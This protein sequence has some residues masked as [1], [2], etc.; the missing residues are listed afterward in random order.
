MKIDYNAPIYEEITFRDIKLYSKTKNAIYLKGISI[1]T[2]KNYLYNFDENNQAI[3]KALKLIDFNLY[4]KKR[5][6]SY[7]LRFHRQYDSQMR[8]LKLGI[9]TKAFPN[10]LL[11]GIKACVKA[12]SDLPFYEEF[13]RDYFICYNVDSIIE[14]AYTLPE[15]EKEMCKKLLISS[16]QYYRDLDDSYNEL[17][18]KSEET[19]ERKNKKKTKDLKENRLKSKNDNAIEPN[20][21]VNDLGE[22]TE[23]DLKESK[24]S[25]ET[26]DSAKVYAVKAT[27][28]IRQEESPVENDLYNYNSVA[29]E[30]HLSIKPPKSG[31]KEIKETPDTLRSNKSTDYI[32]KQQFNSGIGEKG[33]KLVLQNEIAKLKKWGLS[34]GLIQKVRRV[35]LE[36]DDYGYDILS[37]DKEG[38]EH[39]IEV[40]TTTKDVKKFSFII[41]QNELEKAKKYAEHYSVAIVFDILD[42]P[43]I[44]YMGN[45]FIE[46]PSMVNIKPIKY[47]VEVNI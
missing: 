32:E 11:N 10:S 33:E 30:V 41:T 47:S 6:R 7:I 28:S 46:E 4:N 40:K 25:K 18:Y 35:S 15:E 29:E 44:W 23:L 13:F 1:D 21:I 36:S 42:R 27:S 19:K 5:A 20:S 37:F 9:S 38:R 39:Y 8:S 31:E 34:D 22:E 43:K 17:D 45:P 24:N 12:K 14:Y 2:I 3:W 26:N 16:I